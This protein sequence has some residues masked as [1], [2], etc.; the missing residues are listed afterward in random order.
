[1]RPAMQF[2]DVASRYSSE[3][4]VSN[5]ETD[6]D[7]KSIMQ[8]TML[9]ATCGTILTIRAEGEDASSALEELRELVEV[10]MFDEKPNA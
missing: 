6:V 8:M 7:A 9:A 1:M 10:K 2:V 5:G 3:I 4:C